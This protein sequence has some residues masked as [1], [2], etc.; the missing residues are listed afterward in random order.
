MSE[1]HEIAACPACGSQCSTCRV[2]GTVRC[3]V[4]LYRVNDQETHNGLASRIPVGRVR[5]VLRD[6]TVA[7]ITDGIS[8]GT[9][10]RCGRTA[11]DVVCRIAAR[12]GVTLEQDDE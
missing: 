2:T 8:A 9:S 3:N 4:C 10:R 11:T 7:P 12:L 1:Q 6:F 5:E